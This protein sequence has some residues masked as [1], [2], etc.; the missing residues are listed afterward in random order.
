MIYFISDPFLFTFRSLYRRRLTLYTLGKFSTMG[1]KARLVVVNRYALDYISLYCGFLLEFGIVH[2]FRS[3]RPSLFGLLDFGGNHPHPIPY[4]A[5]WRF[6]CM[7]KFQYLFGKSSIFVSIFGVYSNNLV[8]SN[9]SFH[10]PCHHRTAIY[11]SSSIV[12]TYRM[13]KFTPSKSPYYLH[14]TSYDYFSHCTAF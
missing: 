14:R 12:W 3:E 1:I 5:N 9:Q 2:H 8:L 7:C 13:T 10:I 11:I 6:I 4:L